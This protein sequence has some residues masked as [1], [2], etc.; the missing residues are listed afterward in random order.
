MRRCR[1]P[2]IDLILPLD[3]EVL[4][5]FTRWSSRR[6]RRWSDRWRQFGFGL[7]DPREG[8]DPLRYESDCGLVQVRL[9]ERL[10]ASIAVDVGGQTVR[11][12]PLMRQRLAAGPARVSS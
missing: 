3:D 9:V 10:P 7:P 8:S 12:L 11:V 6:G 5:R 1:S 4:D 2:T